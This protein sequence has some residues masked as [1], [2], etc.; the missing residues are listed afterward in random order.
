MDEYVQRLK[1]KN[2]NIPVLFLETSVLPPLSWGIFPS[3][4]HTIL[5]EK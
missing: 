4:G 2:E 1:Q 5:K 3:A